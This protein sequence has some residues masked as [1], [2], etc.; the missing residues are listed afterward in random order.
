MSTS[1]I[2]RVKKTIEQVLLNRVYYIG[3]SEDIFQADSRRSPRPISVFLGT[4]QEII[5]E[6]STVYSLP[7]KKK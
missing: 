6:L 2:K 1:K 7:P 5:D 3:L 4:P